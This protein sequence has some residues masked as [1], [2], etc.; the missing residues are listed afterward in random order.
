MK[1]EQPYN[2]LAGDVNLK[3]RIVDSLHAEF[4]GAEQQEQVAKKEKGKSWKK[5]WK[6]VRKEG[7]QLLKEARRE[8]KRQIKKSKPQTPVQSSYANTGSYTPST[9]TSA[10]GQRPHGMSEETYQSVIDQMKARPG[11]TEGTMGMDNEMNS[12]PM[13]EFQAYVQ[14]LEDPS[15]ALKYSWKKL[16]LPEG[17]PTVGVMTMA[18]NMRFVIC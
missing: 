10:P 18:E 9:A 12:M 8:Y 15:K 2:T 16:D 17:H 11:D 5:V 6:P 7:K 14:G 3:S 13:D 1:C 4:C